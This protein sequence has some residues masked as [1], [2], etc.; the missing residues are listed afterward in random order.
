MSLPGCA[1]A[2][3]TNSPIDFAAVLFETVSTSG[4]FATE[5][6]GVNPVTESY[7][8]L[9]WIAAAVVNDDERKS[10]V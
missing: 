2:S 9:V 5:A 7:G 6:I 4:P 8:R 10:N 3:V 1:F